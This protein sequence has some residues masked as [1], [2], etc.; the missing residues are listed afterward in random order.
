MMCAGFIHCG[1]FVVLAMFFVRSLSEHLRGNLN[2]PARLMK[3]HKRVL[4]LPTE[5]SH[6]TWLN[7]PDSLKKLGVRIYSLYCRKVW[8]SP[9]SA[10]LRITIP[11]RHVGPFITFGKR[12]PDI[13]KDELRLVGD[14]QH[15][16]SCFDAP[17]FKFL[18]PPSAKCSKAAH[19]YDDRDQEAKESEHLCPAK[20]PRISHA[21][22]SKMHRCCHG[23]RSKLQL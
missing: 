5:Q 11:L 1:I 2:V 16:K 21:S 18:A 14:G 10:I 8:S 19:G 13:L 4:N 20:C 6:T 12:P 15:I 17:L 3:F 7:G 9:T 23:Q 22:I